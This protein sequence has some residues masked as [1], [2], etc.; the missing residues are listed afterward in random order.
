MSIR[1]TKNAMIIAV[2]IVLLTVFT[3]HALADDDYEEECS[4]YGYGE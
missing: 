1:Q 2:L 4:D 3:G